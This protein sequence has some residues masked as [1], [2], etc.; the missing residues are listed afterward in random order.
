VILVHVDCTNSYS[1]KQMQLNVVQLVEP[2]P[3]TWFV[4]LVIQKAF[5]RLVLLVQICEM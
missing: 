2:V 5:E 1:A 3:S 4:R